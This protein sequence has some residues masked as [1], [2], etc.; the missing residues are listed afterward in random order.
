MQVALVVGPDCDMESQAVRAALEC[1]GV[2][3]F[4]YW[5]GRPNDLISVLS[6][7]DVYD[8]TDM[9]LLNFHGDEGGLIMP[10]LG[11]EVYEEEEP[12]GDF[13]ADE[14]RRYAKLDGKTV[15]A[16]GRSLGTQHWLKLSWS[17]VARCISGRMTIRTATMR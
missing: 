1:F 8:G 16:N 4:T 6:G 5:I 15:I 7:D 17:G 9:I 3:V 2:R 14:I 11:E 13:G 10:E 12:K